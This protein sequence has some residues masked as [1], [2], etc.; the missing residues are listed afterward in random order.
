MSGGA[1]AI[2]GLLAAVAILA[3]LVPEPAAAQNATWKQTPGTNNFFDSGNWSAGSVPTDTATF[4]VSSTT[5][6]NLFVSGWVNSV[7]YSAGQQVTFNGTRYVVLTP[8]FNVVPGTD[9]SVWATSPSAWSNAVAYNTTDQVSLNGVNYASLTTNFNVTPGTNSSVWVPFTGDRIGGFTLTPGASNYTFSLGG[10]TLTF[11][12][13]GIVVNG[14]SVNLVNDTGVLT[15]DESS[16]AGSATITTNSGAQTFLAS[17]ASG[18]AARFVLNGTG[19][20]DMSQLTT[21]GTT[22]GSV[23]GSG[24]I[25]LGAKN[26]T[27]GGNN[28]S[29]IFSG[30][31]RDGGAAGGTGGSLTKVGAGTLTLTGVNPYTGAT[32][33]NGGVLDV[34]GSITMSSSVT[35]NAGAVLTGTGHVDPPIVTIASGATLAPGNR[36][37]GSA[38]NMAGNLAFQSGAIYLVQLDPSTASFAT[39]A[40]TATLGGAAVNAVFANGSYISKTYTILAATGGVSGSFASNVVATNM[41]ANFSS[42]LSYDATHAYLNLSLNYTPGV[43]V[44]DLSGGLSGNQRAVAGAL[45]NSFNAHGGIPLV[46]GALGPAGLSQAAGELG[47]SSQQTT[48]TAM[49]QFM[50]LLTDPLTQRSGESGS[51]GAA[52]GLADEAAAS[53][54]AAHKRTDAFAMF[55]KAPPVPFAQRWSVWAMGFGGSQSTEGNAVTGSNSTRSDVYGTAVG[56]DYRFSPNTLA[57]FALAGGGTSF[58]V[59]GFGGGRSDLFQAGAYLRHF[60]GPAYVAAALAYG[61]QDITTDRTVTIAG[62]DRLRAEFNA[63]TYSGR[64]EG[65]YRLLIQ[66]VGVTPYAAGQF[67]TFDLPAYAEQ[68][69]AGAGTFALAYGARSV[70]DTRSEL[71]LRADKSLAMP[72]GVLTLRGRLAW[73]HDF[74]PDRSVAATFQALPGASFVTNGAALASESA[75]TTASI[76][77][78]WLNGWSAAGTFEGEFSDVTRSYA[79]K[80]VVRYRW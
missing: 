15:F 32:N 40:G 60:N 79:G 63:N 49:S 2:A 72:D 39:V 45:V 7:V 69:L 10:N 12:G 37:P 65:G 33:V 56:A 80:G 71:G 6:L 11:A 17:S 61:W 30:A 52:L 41:P 55:S 3:G 8:N 59:N 24:T 53:A 1:T 14:G 36:T 43:T 64:L 19:V 78:K 77:M 66:G 13:A 26:L 21:G 27:V 18:G 57:G 34:Q 22:A 68:A 35:V 9:P 70:T 75:L 42:S 5:N 38:M 67:T 29:T 76:E 58:G 23:E 47:A 4:G 31:L 20:L 62:I 28:L 46:F 44:P 25:F 16:T 51:A 73:A 48:F 50:G 54:Y 74:N